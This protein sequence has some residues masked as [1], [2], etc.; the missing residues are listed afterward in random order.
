MP[1]TLDRSPSALAEGFV[2]ELAHY[3]GLPHR[4]GEA[5]DI[6]YPASEFS[7]GRFD[8]FRLAPDGMSG[9]NKSS[10]EGNGEHPTTLAPLIWP[11][12]IERRLA[13][14]SSTNT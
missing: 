12:L 13:F 1:I 7:G 4:P 6:S 9:H 2:H 11:Y 14:V 5:S 8:G 3:F 10:I